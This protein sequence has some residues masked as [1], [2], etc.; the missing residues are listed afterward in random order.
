MLNQARSIC[1]KV[2]QLKQSLFPN[3]VFSSTVYQ[4]LRTSG[5]TC[6]FLCILLGVGVGTNCSLDIIIATDLIGLNLM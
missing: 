3:T 4:T 5:L 1:T 2:L 6:L